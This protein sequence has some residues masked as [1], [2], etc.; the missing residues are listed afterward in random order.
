MKKYKITNNTHFEDFEKIT[1]NNENKLNGI[2]VEYIDLSTFS[3]EN[4]FVIIRVDIDKMPRVKAAQ[5][6]AYLRN[7]LKLCKMLEKKHINYNIFACRSNG[8][9]RM[10]VSVEYK[11]NDNGQVETITKFDEAMKS[12]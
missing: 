1:N 7:E 4:G 10:A 6:I 3:S 8:T 5:Y 12:I 11:E 9:N 2:E